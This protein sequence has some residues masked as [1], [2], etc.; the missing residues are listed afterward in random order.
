MKQA[1]FFIIITLFAAP[2]IAAEHAQTGLQVSDAQIVERRFSSDDRIEQMIRAAVL[3]A[4]A[5]E[6]VESGD[7][8]DATLKGV[9]SRRYSGLRGFVE[10]CMEAE[11]VPITTFHSSD[12]K[13][14]VFGV[15][16]DGILGVHI[17]MK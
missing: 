13:R 7:F 8:Y 14:I 11:V 16:F 4:Q 17:T 9:S 6:I 12:D 2:G 1:A 10:D 3:Q 5:N 15:N